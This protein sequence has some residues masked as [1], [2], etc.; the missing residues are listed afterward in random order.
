[1]LTIDTFEDRWWEV[2]ILPKPGNSANPR[3]TEM[4]R[5]IFVVVPQSRVAALTELG[6]RPATLSLIW[7]SG[8][9]LEPAE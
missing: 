2:D 6:F 5:L 3:V 9:S 8:V 4:E 1:V 7:E